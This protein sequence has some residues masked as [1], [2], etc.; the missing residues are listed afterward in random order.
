MRVLIYFLTVMLIPCCWAKGNGKAPDR[1]KL[2]L[3]SGE[4]ERSSAGLPYKPYS[5]DYQNPSQGALLKAAEDYEYL[6]MALFS[7]TVT[8][9]ETATHKSVIAKFDEARSKVLFAS[10]P[11]LLP[12]F[13]EAQDIEDKKHP[14]IKGALGWTGV[15]HQWSAAALNP[16]VESLL[17]DGQGIICDGILFTRGGLKELFTALYNYSK[18]GKEQVGTGNRKREMMPQEMAAVSEF[19]LNDEN[20]FA[21]QDFESFLYKHLKSG[22]GV[23]MD[24]DPGT[25]V[26]NHPIYHANTS[27]KVMS[28]DELVANE[29]IGAGVPLNY[30]EP[31]DQESKEVMKKMEDIDRFILGLYQ[32]EGLREDA[33]FQ[34]IEDEKERKKILNPT[35]EELNALG[36]KM[37]LYQKSMNDLLKKSGRPEDNSLNS[38]PE[39]LGHF[40]KMR[41]R[42]RT[43]VIASLIGKN[44]LTLK[45]GVKI[46]Y[47]ETT[48]NYGTEVEFGKSKDDHREITYRYLTIEKDGKVEDSSWIT[49]PNH[50][51]DFLWTIPPMKLSD[52]PK[53]HPDLKTAGLR[54]LTQ[55]MEKCVKVKDVVNF[56]QYVDNA[57]SDNNLTV[58]ERKAIGAQSKL[59]EKVINKD[60]LA[61]RMKG[62]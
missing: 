34:V 51:P 42:L 17:G 19:A 39:V 47:R 9:K 48:V 14:W 57:V 37:E 58:E 2:M 44:K 10:G 16:E 18:E 33:I 6:D 56:F 46:N 25:Q 11:S 32:W 35:S 4:F 8:G 54:D 62:L 12:S 38:S 15:C 3:E 24:K 43:E 28:S 27:S 22:Q 1:P 29:L 61:R 41:K 53:D 59:Y 5:S 36:D 60:E 30:F 31:Q 20:G 13:Q 7:P 52:I 26:W 49:A 45:K 50:R 40:I 21:P 23:V 55:L